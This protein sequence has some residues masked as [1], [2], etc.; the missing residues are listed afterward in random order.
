MRRPTP[1]FRLVAVPTSETQPDATVVRR[2]GHHWMDILVHRNDGFDDAIRVEAENLPPGVTCDPVV[3]GPGKYSVPLVF[4]TADDAPL[5]QQLIR[6]VGKANIDGTE[7]LRVARGGGLVWGT[8][9][10]PGVA[11][12]TDG[13]ALAVREAAPFSVAAT[14]SKTTV[15][16]GEKLAIAVKVA[17]AKD[18]A[19]SVQF[20]GYDLPQNATVGLVTVPNGAGEGKV[21]LSVPANLKP[22]TYTFILTAAGQVPRD[23]ALTPASNTPRGNGQRMRVV[24]PTNAITITVTAAK[25]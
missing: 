23:Y 6:I 20:S 25:N 5:A 24:Y 19:E 14:P 4:K 9:N 16:P 22:G 8:T 1:D 21:E 7:T 18:W 15:A 3:I 2:G 13:I 12:L 10:T 17:R 11:R